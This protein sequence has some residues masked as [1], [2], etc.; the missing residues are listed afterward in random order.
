MVW[1]MTTIMVE[2][3]GA[4]SRLGV[5]LLEESKRLKVVVVDPGE[6]AMVEPLPPFSTL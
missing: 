5:K 3:L 6:R 1:G 4:V 2:R